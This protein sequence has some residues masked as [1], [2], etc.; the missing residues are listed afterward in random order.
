MFRYGARVW[1]RLL[2]LN[3]L[4][5]VMECWPAQCSVSCGPHLQRHSRLKRLPGR[6]PCHGHGS[7][8]LQA[9]SGSPFGLPTCT[10]AM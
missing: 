6:E 4:L 8:L 2:Q 3:P 9:S 7:S 10:G 5:G 1:L